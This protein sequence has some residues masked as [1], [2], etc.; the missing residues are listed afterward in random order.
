MDVSKDTQPATDSASQSGA[1]PGGPELIE[2]LVSATGLPKELVH[3]ELDEICALSGQ[4]PG[5]LTLE[6][7]RAAMLTYLQALESGDLS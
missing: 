2:Q 4:N 7:L 1:E 3:Q 6:Q 5:E